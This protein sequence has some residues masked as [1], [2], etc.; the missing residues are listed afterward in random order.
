MNLRLKF[1]SGL[2]LFTLLF[3]AC[4]K[5]DDTNQVKSLALEAKDSLNI[6][7]GDNSKQTLDLYL[8]ANRDEN[9]K[10]VVLVHGGFWFQGDKVDLG[11]YAKFLQS[12]GFAVANINYRLTNTPENNIHPA[13]VNDIAK[14]IDSVSANAEKLHV[15]KSKFAIIGASSRAHLA[16]LYTYAFEKKNRVKTVIAI[17]GPTNLTDPTDIGDFQKLIA[18][19]FLG[20]TLE[21]NPDVY[22]KAS[23]IHYVCEKTKPTL[24][25]HGTNDLVVPFKQAGD[26]KAKLDQY[27]VPNNLLPVSS[28]HDD[29]INP[30]NQ[31]LVLGNIVAWLNIYLN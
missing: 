31:A 6:S 5:D 26:L 4:S 2:T 18:G 9:T 29:V 20:T 14:A 28:G 30:G 25:I 23:P 1:L 21:Q 19:W 12:Q 8:P 10:V 3:A 17:A 15:S 16:L 13:Q 27:N 11:P 24:L 7:Y 22:L